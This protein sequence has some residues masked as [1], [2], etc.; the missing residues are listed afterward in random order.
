MRAARAQSQAC[1]NPQVEDSKAAAVPVE[2]T[3]PALQ[4]LYL[5]RAD[6][7]RLWP[8]ELHMQAGGLPR[9]P[10]LSHISIDP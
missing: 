5:C 8:L 3:A 4:P 6:F 9:S 10:A 2:L 7:A 1:Y